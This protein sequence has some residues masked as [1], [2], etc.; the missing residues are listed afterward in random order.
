MPTA[1]GRYRHQD[2]L[3]ETVA[4][5]T[6]DR[7]RMEAFD[8]LTAAGVPAAPVLGYRDIYD[9][10]HL[11]ARGFF[12]QVTH[13]EAGTWD[14]ERPLYRFARR[15]TSIE[16]NGPCFGEH[17]AYVFGELLGLSDAEIA[18]LEKEGVAARTPNMSS[19]Q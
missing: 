2:E 8:V 3:D 6:R 1:D 9:N 13:P 19:H 10:P 5:W 7:S 4:A 14:M 11:R 15:P 12:E 17:N 18:Q 16:R